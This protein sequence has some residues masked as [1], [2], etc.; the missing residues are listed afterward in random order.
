MDLA[1]GAASLAWFVLTAAAEVSPVVGTRLSGTPPVVPT[2]WAL[3]AA[4]SAAE[5]L[6]T[7]CT[8]PARPGASWSSGGNTTSGGA[9]NCQA[10]EGSPSAR[11]EEPD[12][13]RAGRTHVDAEWGIGVSLDE[14]LTGEATSVQR[15]KRG[16]GFSLFR[17]VEIW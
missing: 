16:G 7:L 1:A 6:P 17:D 15:M 5:G 4:R 13:S 9:V 8:A 2:G 14:S 10:C 11:R 12:G 3:V